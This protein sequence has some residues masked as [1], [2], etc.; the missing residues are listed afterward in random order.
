LGIAL[1]A[2]V[3]YLPNTGVPYPTLLRFL[4]GRFPK[5]PLHIWFERITAGKV[6]T[7]EGQPIT[8]ETT[9]LP[10]TRLFYYREV[11]EEPAIPFQEEILFQNDH[12]LVAC[13][14]PFLPVTPTGPYVR[15]TL[16]GR[17]MEQTGN[18]FLSP[19]N[20]IDRETAGLVL[21]STNKTSR[22]AYQRLFME[23]CVRKTYAAVSYFPHDT[24]QT[25]W[26]IENRIEESEPW[27]RMRSCAGMV[28]ARSRIRLVQT[29]GRQ[30]LFLLHPLTGKKHQLRLHLSDL[31]FPII[32]DRCY[33]TLLKK[34]QDDFSQPLQ[35]LSRK[36]EFRDP[37]SGKEMVFET[38]RSLLPFAG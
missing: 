7:E 25:E 6:L 27:F 12:L 37:L 35:L 23:G 19:I 30:A 11:A 1:G 31:G 15:E 14:P 9:Y 36:I 38:A 2:S 17:L 32:H 18:P 16:I 33:P 13:K 24:G 28:N 8:L 3:V 10:D 22:G 5:I 4:A 20:R 21:V 26:L 29:N 34:R